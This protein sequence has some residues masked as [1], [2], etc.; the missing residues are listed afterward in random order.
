[1]GDILFKKK[2]KNIVSTVLKYFLIIITM[3]III[4]EFSVI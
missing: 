4:I 3:I 1:M 2:Y